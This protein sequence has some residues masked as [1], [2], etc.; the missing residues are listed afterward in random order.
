M[1]ARKEIPSG[2]TYRACGVLI[3]VGLAYS[4][5]MDDPPPTDTHGASSNQDAEP[6]PTT[7]PVTRRRRKALSR[8]YLQVYSE[9]DVQEMEHS[10]Q[11]LSRNNDR[12]KNYEALISLLRKKNPVG[13]RKLSKVPREFG[14][15]LN[16]LEQEMPNFKQVVN[17]IRAMLALQVGGLY[18]LSL[19]TESNG[20]TW[21]SQRV[22]VI[23]HCSL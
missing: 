5:D 3:P 20:S 8:R 11:S 6:S 18:Y 14:E 2:Y 13:V 23:C 19:H 4:L 16:Q 9:D 7:R 1:N 17:T 12:R 22:Y 21:S 10:L 15:R